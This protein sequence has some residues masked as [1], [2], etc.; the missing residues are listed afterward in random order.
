MVVF[1][2]KDRAQIFMFKISNRNT[3]IICEICSEV[4]IM[5]A[6]ERQLRRSCVFSVNF[7]QISQI[8]MVFPL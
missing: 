2:I 5:T 3:R 6:E 1:R 7:E 8:V 4:T